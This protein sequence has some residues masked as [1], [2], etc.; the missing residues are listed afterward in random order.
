VQY[1]HYPGP[2]R[3]WIYNSAGEHI[4]TLDDLP[5]TGPI[6]RYYNWDGK[7][8]YGEDC[9]SGIYIIFLVETYDRKARRVILIR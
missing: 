6:D 2:Y 5:L 3:L 1:N 9:A 4:R 8:K 7:N